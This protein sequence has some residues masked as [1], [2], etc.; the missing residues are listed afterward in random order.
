MKNNFTLDP[1]NLLLLFF[2]SNP[3]AMAQAPIS[4]IKPGLVGRMIQLERVFNA[5]GQILIQL[6]QQVADNQREIDQLRGQIQENQYQLSQYVNQK[7]QVDIQTEHLIK[8]PIYSSKEN[9]KHL[10]LVE[11]AKDLYLSKHRDADTDYNKA[12]SL[13]MK[14]K[15]YDQAIIAFQNFIKNHPNSTYQSNANYWLGQLNYKKGNSDSAAYYFALVVKEHP[16][17]SKAPE[18]L[19]KVGIIM[20]EKGQNDKARAVFKQVGKLY[21]SADAAKQAQK[22]LAKL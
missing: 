10:S 6:Q 5:H 21:P 15:Q 18:S 12:L 22:H 9:I 20:Q 1:T 2:L 16:Q 17:S 8:T 11:N 14:K 19:L 4:D 13:V 3:I 7:K